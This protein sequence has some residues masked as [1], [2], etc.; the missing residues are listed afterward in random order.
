MKFKS[1]EKKFDLIISML[2]ENLHGRILSDSLTLNN[3]NHKCIIEKN[4]ERSIKRENWL[5]ASNIGPK[6]QSEK[7]VV[8]NIEDIQVTNIY[9]SINS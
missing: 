1:L 4:T 9:K 7:I 3:I 8:D 2:G 5:S 6:I